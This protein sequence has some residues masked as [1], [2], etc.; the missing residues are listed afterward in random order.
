M[1]SV[2]SSCFGILCIDK[3]GC[4]SHK[5]VCKEKNRQIHGKWH[6]FLLVFQSIPSAMTPTEVA[7]SGQEE[8]NVQ[9]IRVTCWCIAREAAISVNLFLM[10]A[11]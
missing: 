8:E 2:L 9:G 6:Y 10:L 7:I 11:P 3:L 4:K 1:L 5:R